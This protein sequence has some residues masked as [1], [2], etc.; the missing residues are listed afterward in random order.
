[1]WF[2]AFAK[3]NLGLVVHPTSGGL[4]PVEALNLSVGWFDRLALETADA[5]HQDIEGN[6]P[7]DH[8]NLAWKA[9]TA[10]RGELEQPL[11]LRLRKHI[12]AAAGLGGGSADAAAALAACGVVLGIDDATLAEI[13]PQLGSD[14][15]FCFVGGLCVVGGIG[16]KVTKLPTPDGFALAIVVPPFELGSSAVYQAWD[17]AGGPSGPSVGDK[18]LPPM[19]RQY[20]PLRNDLYP[21][22]VD[23]RPEVDEWRHEM[24]QRWDREVFLSGSGPALFSYFVDIDE[25]EAALRSVPTGLRAAHAAE[26]VAS[27]WRRARQ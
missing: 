9:V 16:D 2:E 11:L 7:L 20:A 1:M 8:A 17:D 4:H 15:P 21:A 25:A 3:V 22:A 24:A 12:P 13:A 19:L 10:A 27:G 5:D 6:V 14:V 23:I 26:P 18:H